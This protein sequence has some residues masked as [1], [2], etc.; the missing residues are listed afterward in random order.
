MT[1]ALKGVIMASVALFSGGGVAHTAPPGSQ[2]PLTKEVPPPKSPLRKVEA[3]DLVPWKGGGGG[4]IGIAHFSCGN[5]TQGYVLTAT[6]TPTPPPWGCGPAST[7]GS[8]GVPPYRPQEARGV[9]S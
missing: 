5:T 8:M 6:L 1:H 3:P 7:K 4:S 9:R 2:P